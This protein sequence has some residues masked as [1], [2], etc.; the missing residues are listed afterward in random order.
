MLA[1][2]APPFPKPAS[3]IAATPDPDVRA[4]PP[5][6]PM[7]TA[8]IA[9]KRTYD[10]RDVALDQRRGGE[11]ADDEA[12]PRA[13]P[14]QAEAEV[15]GAERLL[16]EE[17]L[18]DVHDPARDHHDRPDDEHARERPRVPHDREAL[19]EVAPAAAA[20]RAVALQQPRR[21]ERRRARP[22][23]R[24]VD[25]VDDVGEMRARGGDEHAAER[26]ARAR[27]SSSR[28][29]G[30]ARSP[31]RSSSS[32]T[33]FGSPASTAGRKNAFPIPATTASATIAA[34]RVRRTGAPRRRRAGRDR[35][36]SS[37]A[38]ARAGRRAARAGGR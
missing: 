9:M 3:A 15:A 25:G 10:R 37:A 38:C 32:A 13:G 28:R 36:R 19:G 18:G 26:A 33:R 31:A 21:D 29:A 14:E 7:P 27:S 24:S 34:G 35:R 6:T 8:K 30:A 20:D 17:H 16:G 1:T 5:R 4:R 2:T 23:A 12:D 11:P 22:R